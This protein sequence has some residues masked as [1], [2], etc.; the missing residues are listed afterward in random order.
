M[1]RES[2]STALAVLATVGGLILVAAIGVGI[3]ALT[4]ATAETRGRIALSNQQRTPG[5]LQASYEYFHDTC[6]SIIAAGQQL[7]TLQQQLDSTPA[8][9]SDPFGQAAQR[10]DQ[11]RGQIAGLSNLRDQKAQ[12]YDAKS[13]EFT[14]NFMRS[15]DLPIEI[16]PPT[17]V[18]YDGLVCESGRS[19]P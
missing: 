8:A 7:A 11:L 15:R 13:H 16:G 5:Q 18:P 17:G 9:T 19:T 6:R 12:D 14:R 3:Y 1:R 4:Y 10:T 2:G